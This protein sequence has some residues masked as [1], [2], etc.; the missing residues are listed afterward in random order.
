M[1]NSF[2]DV[3]DEPCLC[4]G[5]ASDS[6]LTNHLVVGAKTL[7]AVLTLWSQLVLI[8]SV[9]IKKLEVHWKKPL[10]TYSSVSPCFGICN[11]FLVICNF[12]TYQGSTSELG[13]GFH[14]IIS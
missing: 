9:R 8:R 5:L 2:F 12:V 6:V 10:C 14:S 11:I 13:I 3:G 7:P 4:S 1:L